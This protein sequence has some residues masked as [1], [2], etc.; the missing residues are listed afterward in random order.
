LGKIVSFH[1]FLNWSNSNSE[2]TELIRKIGCR[3][4]HFW[5]L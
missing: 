3:W 5:N 4:T 2:L 1:V